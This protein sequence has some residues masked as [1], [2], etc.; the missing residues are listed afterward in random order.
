MTKKITIIA[1]AI[2]MIAQMTSA[3]VWRVNNRANADAD[4]TTLQTAHDDAGVLNGDTLYIGGS[5]TS[6]GTLICTKQLIIIGPGEFLNENSETQAYKEVAYVGQITLNSGSENTII[7][8]LRV[9]QAT[10]YIN[11][12]D[13]TIRRNRF[14]TNLNGYHL[15]YYGV[16]IAG[17]CENVI[18]EGNWIRIVNYNSNGYC[19]GI[20]STGANLTN[21]IIRNNYIYAQ[22]NYYSNYTIR[23]SNT[24]VA[25]NVLI[26]QNVFHANNN[27][28]TISAKETQMY[29]NIMILGNFIPNGSYYNNNISNS[30][31]FG[32]ADGNQ[33]NVSMATV[34]VDYTTGID[35]DLQL[36]PGS[37]A[38]GA[39]LFGEDCGL[40]GGSYPYHISLI[41]AIPAI[42]AVNLN[43]YGSDVVPINVTIKA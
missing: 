6:Y 7:A 12:D 24:V 43:N 26:C 21:L 10:I 36:A 19:Y 33:Q 20:S 40:Y 38:I 3:T 17:N 9:Q 41:P 31:Q 27:N 25:D 5:P 23:L 42:W 14:F 11:T 32:T 30:T 29:N 34:F 22:S 35:S 13:I 18:I 4:F 1:T 8:G 39:G 15:H 28:T 37:P 2:I 16:S